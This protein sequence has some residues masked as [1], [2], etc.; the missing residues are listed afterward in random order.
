MAAKKSDEIPQFEVLLKVKQQNNPDFSFLDAD[1]ILHPFYQWIKNGK[2]DIRT[3]AK[4]L[5]VD[6]D[7][8]TRSEA[9]GALAMY[10]SSSSDSEEDKETA[11]QKQPRGETFSINNNT[12]VNLMN[13]EKQQ[14][15]LPEI[16]T[17]VTEKNSDVPVPSISTMSTDEQK[18]QRL[19]RA[20]LL[21]NHF[22]SKK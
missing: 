16:M 12:N 17:C 13:F 6:C 2:P 1:D 9:I 8:N 7:T 22:L 5:S 10:G 20:K 15:D 11:P 21:R 4:K 3:K 19:K 18:S 14:A